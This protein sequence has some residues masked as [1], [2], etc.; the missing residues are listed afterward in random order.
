MKMEEATTELERAQAL[1]VTNKQ[2]A[3]EILYGL[4]EYLNGINE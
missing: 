3:I 4:G 2:G 1:S